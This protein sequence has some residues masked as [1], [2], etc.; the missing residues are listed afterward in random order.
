IRGL[1]SCRR[2]KGRFSVWSELSNNN[3]EAWDNLAAVFGSGFAMSDLTAVFNTFAS[4]TMLESVKQFY[5]TNGRTTSANARVVNQT[6]ESI[7]SRQSWLQGNRGKVQQFLI[8]VG[9]YPN[10]NNNNN[11]GGHGSGGGGSSDHWYDEWW[12]ILIVVLIALAL[13]A[14]VIYGICRQR[15][16]RGDDYLKLANEGIRPLLHIFYVM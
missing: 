14:G 2:C 16:R 7:D 12:F 15:R 9:D 4:E 6:L 11:N 5:A 3:G 10:D 8:A 13:V 1:Y